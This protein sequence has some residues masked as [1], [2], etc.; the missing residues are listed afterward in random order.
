MKISLQLV[1]LFLFI[2]TLIFYWYY[3]KSSPKYIVLQYD[4]RTIKTIYKPLIERNK[5]YCKM[6]GYQ[7]T[8][9]KSGYDH[10]P[11]YWRKVQ[12]T[13]D[14]LKNNPSC[15]G[16]MWL[17]TDAAI[18]DYKKTIEGYM[19]PEKSMYIARQSNEP[20]NSGVWFVRNDAKGLEIMNS[21][22]ESYKETEWVKNSGSWQT[23]GPFGG[24]N[25][26]QGSFI[27]RVYPRYISE[28]EY[29][30]WPVLQSQTI[31]S[32]EVFTVHFYGGQDRACVDFTDKYGV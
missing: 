26:E 16:V 9:V 15:K 30:E 11:P 14:T 20:F 18:A 1:I 19:K 31:T 22:L 3:T 8:F 29:Y 4:D 24:V 10:L 5:K 27:Q 2:L 23:S 7:H 25:Y 21:W 32:D 28:T 12:L 6:N 13:I 17:D